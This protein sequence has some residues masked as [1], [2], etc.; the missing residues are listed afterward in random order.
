MVPGTNRQTLFYTDG[1]RPTRLETVLRWFS[2][3][4]YNPLGFEFVSSV[5]WFQRTA[6][7]GLSGI[8][9]FGL[10]T[11]LTLVATGC[12]TPSHAGNGA[13]LG[14]GL[15]AFTGAVIGSGSGHA[16]GGAL[17]GAAAGALTGGLIGDAMDAREERDAAIAHAQYAQAKSYAASQAL[18]TYDVVTMTL[19]GVS[20]DVII[21]A[22]RTR[23]C[24][25]DGAPDT[26]ISLKQQ[27]VSDRVITAMQSSYHAPPAAV[28]TSPP[29]VVYAPAPAIVAPPPVVVYGPVY[30]PR[31]YWGPP[32]CYHHH[33]HRGSSRAHF[34]VR[35]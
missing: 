12:Q 20:D 5:I 33:Y 31:R 22:L 11:L 29:A 1:R 25:F 32:P 34:S 9:G 4:R 28:V 19:N 16:G 8:A 15:G 26:I 17:I 13:A 2:K 30:G 27:G 7:R 18:S 3:C 6:M 23:G 10:S 21:N 14:T 24:R 35:F